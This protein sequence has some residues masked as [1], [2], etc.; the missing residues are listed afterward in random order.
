MA[1]AVIYS[2]AGIKKE[3][4]AK[5]SAK[6]FAVEPNNELINQAYQMYLDNGRAVS[7][8]TLSRGMVR[9]GGRKP[10][11]QKGTGRARA[12]S[13]RIPHWTGG[14]VAFGPTGEQNYTKDMPVKAKRLAIRQAL[15]VKAKAK[16]ILVLE[17]FDGGQGKVKDTVKLLDKL[18]LE[19]NIVL[20]V[21]QK[22]ELVDRATRNIAG[23][24]AVSAKYLNV[25]TV[26]NAQWLVFTSEAQK[27]VTEWLETGV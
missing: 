17:S 3:A 19:G 5:L 10:H 1:Q 14:G 20:V 15:S 23:V 8:K 26:M 27:Q 12:G 16:Q 25:F 2:K 7:A 6:V 4:P 9:G 13:I 18:K 21:D 11:R 24:K 22:T